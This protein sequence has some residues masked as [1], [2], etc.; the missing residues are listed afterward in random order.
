[1]Y[2]ATR[3]YW[4]EGRKHLERCVM[5]HECLTPGGGCRSG[6]HVPPPAWSAK[7]KVIHGLKLS[8]PHELDS[9]YYL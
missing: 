9:F 1:M 7:L 2:T 5:L 8:K 3:I 4:K 6:M